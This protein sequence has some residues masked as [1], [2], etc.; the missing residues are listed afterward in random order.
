MW[1]SL[2]NVATA[3]WLLLISPS[4]PGPEGSNVRDRNI[5]RQWVENFVSCVDGM[6]AYELVKNATFM[7]VGG[8]GETHAPVRD[9]RPRV[10]LPARRRLDDVVAAIEPRTR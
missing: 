2:A 1:Q 7:L 8:D 9:S 4:A 3:S 5:V 10:L 6:G